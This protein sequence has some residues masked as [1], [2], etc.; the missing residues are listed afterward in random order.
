MKSNHHKS[1]SII[2]LLS[3]LTGCFFKSDISETNRIILSNDHKLTLLNDSI[4]IYKEPAGQKTAFNKVPSPVDSNFEYIIKRVANLPSISVD[5]IAVQANDIV[6]HGTTAVITYNYAGDLFTGALQILDI[7][8]KTAPV[9]IE[10]WKFPSIDIN[11][12]YID[13]NTVLFGGAANPD[14]WNFRSC[15]GKITLNERNSESIESSIRQLPSYALT[16]ITRSGNRYYASVGARDGKLVIL[17]LQ[18]NIINTIDMPDARDVDAF[19][20]GVCVLTGTTDN[21]APSGSLVTFDLNNNKITTINL[22]RF[23]SDYHKATVEINGG[24]TAM[25]GISKGGCN[26]YDLKNG[27]ALFSSPNPLIAAPLLSYTNSVSS[28]ANL[29]FTAN[30]NYGF[31]VFKI[32]DAGFSGT[33]LIGYYPFEGLQANN[34]NYSA[35]HIEFKANFLF[36]ASG[37]GGV[38]IY[39]LEKI[40]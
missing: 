14:I 28:D 2:I 16:A 31:R 17:D 30:G 40:I 20:G 12:A 5:T 37:V 4:D 1:L 9:I 33:E 26:V 35:N 36:V 18:L 6:I 29:M 10:E 13:G 24:Q 34:I 32:K 27:T 25:T 15:I 3:T 7:S 21:T 8:N 39:Y 38:T 19:S 22:P 23:S 11:A